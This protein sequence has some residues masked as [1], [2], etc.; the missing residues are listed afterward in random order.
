M[1]GCVRVGAAYTMSNSWSVQMVQE[2]LQMCGNLLY[3]HVSLNMALPSLLDEF[4]F[5]QQ[6]HNVLTTMRLNKYHK[7]MI[8]MLLFFEKWVKGKG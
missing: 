7:Q 6:S 8:N 2:A 3:L 1:K 4:Q 5:L